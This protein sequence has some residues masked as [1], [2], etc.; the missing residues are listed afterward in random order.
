MT[1][2]A[3]FPDVERIVA[4][5]LDDLG[6]VGTETSTGLQD[7]LPFIR[8]NRVG[9]GDDRI[10][11]QPRVTVDV[12]TA[13]TTEAKDIAKEAQQRLTSEPHAT[14]HGILD[15]ATTETGPHPISAGDEAWA[16]LRL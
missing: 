1:V 13:G 9:G 8:V 11:D 14:D 5:I 12:F 15:R 16:G 3:P 2:L 6:T 7:V 4:D 10:T